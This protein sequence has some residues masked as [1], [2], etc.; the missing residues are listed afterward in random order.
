MI[1]IESASHGASSVTEVYGMNA[2]DRTE[3][4]IGNERMS[5]RITREFDAFEREKPF[6]CL[7]DCSGIDEFQTITDC[8]GRVYLVTD[9]NL[10]AHDGIRQI[11]VTPIDLDGQNF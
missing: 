3:V 7:S 6:S 1:D 9:I 10:L 11:R 4:V 2:F 8:R 5:F